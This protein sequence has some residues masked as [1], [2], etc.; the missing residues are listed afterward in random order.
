MR[1]GDTANVLLEP[2][3]RERLPKINQIKISSGQKAV[4]SQENIENGIEALRRVSMN[5]GYI[6]ASQ[7]VYNLLTA[8]KTLEQ[9][10]DGNKKCFTLQYIDWTHP[11]NNVFHVT[12]EFAVMRNGL[13]ESYRPD[14]V[15]F[16]NGIPLCVIECKRPDVK[17]SLA[18]A[19]SQHLRN[20][21]A[22]G[23]RQLYMYAALT[24]AVNCND[25]SYATTATPEKFWSKCI[26]AKTKRTTF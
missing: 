20:Q 23:I 11:E 14:I 25:A 6:T 10:I 7:T 26:I 16:V 17:D 13:K 3:L 21:K 8:G 15:L 5:E 12:E 18:Q 1:G 24:V 19:V 9:I 22:D 4:F 2:I